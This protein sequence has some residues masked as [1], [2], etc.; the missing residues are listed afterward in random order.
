MKFTQIIYSLLFV[1]SVLWNI[2]HTF[3]SDWAEFR[4]PNRD[5]ISQETGLLKQW[6]GNGPEL[7]WSVDDCGDCLYLYVRTAENLMARAEAERLVLFV[8]GDDSSQSGYTVGGVGADLMIEISGWNGTVRSSVLMLFDS[9][10]QLDWSKWSSP[11]HVASQ[12]IENK[13]EAKAELPRRLNDSARFVLAAQ[14]ERSVT[15]ISHPVATD[16]TLLIVEQQPGQG[17]ST[18]GILRRGGNADLLRLRLT[19]QGGGGVVESVVP[20]FSWP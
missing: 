15:C 16:R 12:V 17:V 8:D 13:L 9:D 5:G 7:V 4:G 19:C 18:E 2:N 11:T 10:D 6:P 14:N 20:A 3:A 1:C